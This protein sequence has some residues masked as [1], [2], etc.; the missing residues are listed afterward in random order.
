[1]V[2]KMVERVTYLHGDL[3]LTIVEARHL[4]N[5]D[6]VSERFRRCFT[7]CDTIVQ[8]LHKDPK[9][10]SAT[11]DA[12]APATAIEKKMRC[13][14]YPCS[15]QQK[16]S[17][18]LALRGLGHNDVSLNAVIVSEDG[19]WVY[20]GG[21]D[22]FVMGWEASS[23]STSNGGDVQNQLEVSWKP[24]YETK[25]H[26]MAILSMCLMGEP[27]NQ[28]CWAQRC[29]S[30]ELDLRNISKL[31]L[32]PLDVSNYNQT[33]IQ[34]NGWIVSPMDSRYRWYSLTL[35]EKHS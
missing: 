21:S 2:E 5:M 17:A 3:D 13:L 28:I 25:A 34:S 31:I 18:T 14:G 1:M 20:G 33:P 24:V 10:D 6:I 16:R 32:S 15:S 22:E 4:L 30:L 29:A 8:Y 23:N 7:A 26:R 35:H 19:R 9:T 12:A 27:L 11:G